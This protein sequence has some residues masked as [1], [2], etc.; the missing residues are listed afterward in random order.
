MARE[1]VQELFYRVNGIPGVSQK[2]GVD[3]KMGHGYVSR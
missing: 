1:W 3:K 2:L